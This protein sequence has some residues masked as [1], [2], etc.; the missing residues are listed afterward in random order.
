MQEKLKEYKEELQKAVE[1][2]NEYTAIKFRLEGAIM[3]LEEQTK[4]EEVPTE[5]V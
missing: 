5:E 1:L 2:I 3:A 4:L